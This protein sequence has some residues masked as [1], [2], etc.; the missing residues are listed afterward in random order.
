[1]TRKIEDARIFAWFAGEVTCGPVVLE[2]RLG[3]DDVRRLVADRF[4]RFKIYNEMWQ[5]EG[6]IG[7]ECIHVVE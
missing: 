3:P 2:V 1:L 7:P 6:C 4:G 5:L